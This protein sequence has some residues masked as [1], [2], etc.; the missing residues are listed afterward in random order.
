MYYAAYLK[1]AGVPLLDTATEGRRVF[2]QFEKS[3]N[4]GDLK[5][6]YYN[7]KG[8][9][10]ALTYSEEVKVMKSLTAEAQRG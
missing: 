5:R 1:V 10:A 8:K 3:P 7:R 4:L 2:F 6:D 9:V